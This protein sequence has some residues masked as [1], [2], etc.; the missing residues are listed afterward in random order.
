MAYLSDLTK[1]WPWNGNP[2]DNEL[3]DKEIYTHVVHPIDRSHKWRIEVPPCLPGFAY[4][5]IRI[6]TNKPSLLPVEAHLTYGMMTKSLLGD[7]SYFSVNLKQWMPLPYALNNRLIAIGEDAIDIRLTFEEEVYGKVELLA[8]YFLDFGD[9][10]SPL[11]YAY[12]DDK[13]RTIFL[14][15]HNNHFIRS[16]YPEYLSSFS[17]YLLPLSTL[18]QG[19]ST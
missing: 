4:V 12:V 16:I 11:T 7:R 1:Q 8:Q 17:I 15:T 9:D 14:H 13:D 10:K 19:N 2:E 6:I 3:E 18:L 5:G